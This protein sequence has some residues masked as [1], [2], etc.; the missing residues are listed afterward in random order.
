M[1][2]LVVGDAMEDLYWRGDI[3][4]VSPEAPV[5]IITVTDAEKRPGGASNVANNI[6]AMGVQCERMFG[7]SQQRIQKIR[8]IARNQQV[9]RV[10][11]DY[12]Q[13]AIAPDAS[14]EE[15][16]E[17]CKI[18]VFVDYAKGTLV[19]IQP[20]IAKAVAAGCA[21]FIDPKGYD[22]ARYR[23]ASMIKPNQDE[24][25]EMVGGWRT[26]DE[27]DFKVRQFLLASGIESILLTQAQDGLT[28]YTKNQTVHHLPINGAPVD[29]SGAGEAVMAGYAAA[30]AKGHSAE[31]AARYANKAAGVACQ[32]FGTVI[33]EEKDVFA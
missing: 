16:I 18:V 26:Q 28:L 14:Y 20:L 22:Y 12:P 6:E 31:D 29:V 33:V 2:V 4:R 32:H 17:R 5:P 7:A 30:I 19:D 8:L 27:L 11:F 3:R 9:A 13:A 21:V 24:M 10:D 15:A 25:R 23:G 1:R